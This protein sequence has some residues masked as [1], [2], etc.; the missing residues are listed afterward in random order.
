M[1]FLKLMLSAGRGKTFI[2][3][4]VKDK[5]YLKFGARADVTINDISVEER[6][7]KVYLKLNIDADCSSEDFYDIL[8]K[9]AK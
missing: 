6:D 7:G 9:L 2:T 4:W 8:E 1:I 3:N 5:L